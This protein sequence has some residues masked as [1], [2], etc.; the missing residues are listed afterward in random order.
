MP[1]LGEAGRVPSHRNGRARGGRRGNG[2]YEKY[3]AALDAVVRKHANDATTFGDAAAAD[4]E[5]AY[6][7]AWDEPEGYQEPAWDEPSGS[8]PTGA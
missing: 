5:D 2:L 1:K 4:R 7:P 6:D 3:G 8:S